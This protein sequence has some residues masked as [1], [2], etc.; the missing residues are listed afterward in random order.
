MN[1]MLIRKKAIEG[2]RQ[3]SKAF[4]EIGNVPFKEKRRNL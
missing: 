4:S 1:W 3:L 2:L